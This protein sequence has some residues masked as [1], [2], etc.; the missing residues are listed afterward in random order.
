MSDPA[1]TTTHGDIHIETT[2]HLLTS[3]ANPI[4]TTLTFAVISH[5][6]SLELVCISGFRTRPLDLILST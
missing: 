4:L 6:G 3:D 1:H 2:K 5:T